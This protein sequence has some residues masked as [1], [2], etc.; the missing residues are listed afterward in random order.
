MLAALRVGPIA[1]LKMHPQVRSHE[2]A[3]DANSLVQN[4]LHKCMLPGVPRIMAAPYPFRIFQT[5]GQVTLVYEMNRTFR[6]VRM[7]AQHVNPEVWDPSYMGESVGRW[8]GNT[9]VIDTTNFNDR[10]TID[11]SGLPHSDQLHVVER[12]SK[13][14]GGRQLEARITIEDPVTFSKPWTT[15]LVYEWRP[16]IR[17][18]TDWVCDEPHRDLSEVAG[19]KAAQSPEGMK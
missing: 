8:E 15:R 9:L 16:D 14:N 1:D 6:V 18:V 3:E 19:I 17:P 5:P 7:D 11:R 2:Y 12:L 10:T 13:I 4:T